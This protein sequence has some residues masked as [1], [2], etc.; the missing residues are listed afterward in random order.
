[1]PFPAGKNIKNHGMKK[2]DPK[3][4]SGGF[5]S[6]KKIVSMIVPSQTVL[7]VGCGGGNLAKKLAKK[8]CLVIGLDIDPKV[9]KTAAEHYREIVI[10]DVEDQLTLRK[11]NKKKFDV[12]IFSDILEHLKD[13]ENVLK[14]LVKFLATPGKVII[15]VPNIAFLTNRLLAL[16]GRFDYTDWGTMD[17][18]HLRFF[19]K[20][21][22]SSLIKNTGLEIEKFD[23]V[24]NFTQLPFYMRTLHPVFGGRNWWRKVENKITGL[25]PKGLAVQLLFVCKKRQR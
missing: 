4:N 25:W 23:Y 7:D 22:I 15:S 16:L 12:I 9:T 14:N 6:H 3:N 8:K 5:D 11:L 10:G 20:K 17:R 2:D 21:S 19:T 18:T 24:G 13:P 1:M